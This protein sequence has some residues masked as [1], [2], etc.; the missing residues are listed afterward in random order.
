VKGVARVTNLFCHAG[1]LCVTPLDFSSLHRGGN[2][3]RQLFQDGH[4]QQRPA[5]SADG[6]KVAFIICNQLGVDASG[7]VFVF[8]LKGN[9]ITPLRTSTG[10]LLVPDT[11]TKLNWIP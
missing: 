9:D 3:L 2:N 6:T 10:A 1:N 7:E 4:N 5:F 11:S 8:D